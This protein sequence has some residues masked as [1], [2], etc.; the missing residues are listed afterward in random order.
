MVDTPQLTVIVKIILIILTITSISLRSCQMVATQSLRTNLRIIK[1]KEAE[2]T[3]ARTMSMSKTKIIFN[4]SLWLH[5]QMK[6]LTI[7]ISCVGSIIEC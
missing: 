7:K 2:E 5:Y 6:T 3:A 4:R 1:V